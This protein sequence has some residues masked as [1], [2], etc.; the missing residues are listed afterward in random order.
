M[1]TVVI[2]VPSSGYSNSGFGNTITCYFFGNT[3]LPTF[4]CTDANYNQPNADVGTSTC[5][6]GQC[7][8]TVSAGTITGVSPTAYLSGTNTY[9]A[10]ITVPSGYTNAGQTI[11]CTDTATG[12]DCTAAIQAAFSQGAWTQ[13][14]DSRATVYGLGQATGQSPNLNG[15]LKYLSLIHI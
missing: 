12:E 5:K 9:T 2:N 7:L 11:T 3:I 1:Y 10:S 13:T 4:T 14:T 6:P 8:A 15:V